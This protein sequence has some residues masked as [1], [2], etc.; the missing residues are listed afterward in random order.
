[1]NSQKL[2]VAI[3]ETE[4]F[5]E[6]AKQLRAISKNY[7]YRNPKEQGSVKRSSMDLTRVLSDLRKPN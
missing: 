4:R 1:M 3:K 2:D 5:L 7:F 6:R